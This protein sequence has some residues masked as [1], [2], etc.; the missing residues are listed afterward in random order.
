MLS[1]N[2]STEETQ[3]T[4]KLYLRV[5]C[6]ESQYCFELG[7]AA[8]RVVTVGSKPEADVRLC[9]PGVAA[10]HCFIERIGDEVWLVPAYAQ[11]ELRLN[12]APVNAPRQ[13]GR[14][15]VIEVGPN[16]LSVDV[17][18]VNP[19]SHLQPFG[20]AQAQLQSSGAEYLSHLPNADDTTQQPWAA[21]SQIVRSPELATT[22]SVDASMIHRLETE[23][24]GATTMVAPI[25]HIAPQGAGTAPLPPPPIQRV[26]PLKQTLLGV[27]PSY[28]MPH[29]PL[30]P[31][32]MIP[33]AAKLRPAPCGTITGP[34]CTRVAMSQVTTV[35]DPPQL[36]Q[37]PG[38]RLNWLYALG[39]SVKRR[40]ARTVLNALAI[41]LVGSMLVVLL[42]HVILRITIR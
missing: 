23:A 22:V 39:L 24:L 20:P 9:E 41:S 42:A 32:H 13:L 5:R 30:E 38:S 33:P 7:G 40:P 12:A 17:E 36:S 37:P 14:R 4:Q 3:D 10:L 25:A 6:R 26:A 16:F 34:D 21:T 8:E 11:S 2:P 15:N 29:R 28:A 31:P 1:L 35:I 18:A 27:A 19:G